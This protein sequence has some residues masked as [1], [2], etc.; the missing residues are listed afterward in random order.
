MDMLQDLYYACR[1]RNISCECFFLLTTSGGVAILQWREMCTRWEGLRETVTIVIVGKYTGMNDAYL[2]V[3][4]ALQHAALMCDRKVIIEVGTE[5]VRGSCCGISDGWLGRL[6]ADFCPLSLAPLSS[7]LT[8]MY[9][10][11]KQRHMTHT[12]NAFIQTYETFINIKVVLPLGLSTDFTLF[13]CDAVD[14]GREPGEGHAGVHACQVPRG[15]VQAVLRSRHPRPWWLR[16]PR[17]GWQGG[18]GALGPREQDPLPRHLPG[19]A[20]VCLAGLPRPLHLHN[21]RRPSS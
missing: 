16:Q 20:G 8:Y 14:R 15:V 6:W 3:I 19:H 5:H 17:R 9:C 18:G 2:S 10:K 21:T 1:T 12:L 11:L 4:K 13:P 7:S